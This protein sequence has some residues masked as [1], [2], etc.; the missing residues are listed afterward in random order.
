[1][2][3]DVIITG[4]VGTPVDYRSAPEG[5][6][7]A[8][9]RLACTPRRRTRDG[10]WVDEE[11]TWVTVSAARALADN[12]RVSL[13]RGDPV[14]VVGKLRTQ[15]YR[16]AEGVER[17]RF[18]LEASTIG[19]DLARGQSAFT[20]P[21]RQE[22]ADQARFVSAE[23]GVPESADVET[24]AEVTSPI[25]VGTTDIEPVSAPGAVLGC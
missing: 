4:Y 10:E 9:F 15:R 8:D 18:V 11:T 24:S 3:A 7:F 1:M 25:G 5:W 21:R 22:Q 12:I 17:E 14:I 16:T 13:R 2:D 23:P 19:H 20:K 6:R